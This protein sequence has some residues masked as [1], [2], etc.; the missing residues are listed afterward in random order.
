M[1]ASRLYLSAC[2]FLALTA[3]LAAK[4]TDADKTFQ[5]TIGLNADELFPIT[6]QGLVVPDWILW[7]LKKDEYCMEVVEGREAERYEPIRQVT[8]EVEVKKSTTAGRL[9]AK[10][11]LMEE[12]TKIRRVAGKA[13]PGAPH[14]VLLVLDATIGQNG[15]VQAREFLA[16][17]GVTGLVLAK[18]DGT[19]KGGVI[20]AI[21]RE[22][23]LPVRY[24]GLGEGIEDLED[25][26]PAAFASALIEL[27]PSAA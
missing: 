16:A 3:R 17:A 22:T 21:A 4:T 26:D 12:L 1:N 20:L 24:I 23:R 8:F 6:A 5:N 13:L 11:N 7:R 14:E 27:D 9:Q 25:F 15:L 18:L 19:A 2:L 10:G